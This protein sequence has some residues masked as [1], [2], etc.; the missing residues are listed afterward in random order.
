MA[1]MSSLA[2][3]MF[4][5]THVFLSILVAVDLGTYLGRAELHRQKMIPLH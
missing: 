1:G 2:S 4:Q 5:L 3:S